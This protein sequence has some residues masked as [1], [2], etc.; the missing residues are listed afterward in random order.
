MEAINSCLVKGTSFP[1]RSCWC[2]GQAPVQNVH[3]QVVASKNLNYGCATIQE[4]TKPIKNGF[5]IS[6]INLNPILPIPRVLNHNSSSQIGSVHHNLAL[7][8]YSCH[9]T[10]L[11]NDSHFRNSF[12]VGKRHTANHPT[13][14]SLTRL[15]HVVDPWPS[16]V[17][18]PFSSSKTI[19][20]F[21]SVTP[22][23]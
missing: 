20:M 13:S 7:H 18:I 8:L 22:A 9:C 16:A 17:A 3:S 10:K 12:Q 6:S 21:S 1:T 4:P 11:P 2:S 14:I 15:T 19:S 5:F 23:G